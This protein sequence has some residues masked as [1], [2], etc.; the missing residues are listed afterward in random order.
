MTP[1]VTEAA[2]EDLER[3]MGVLML[4]FA[5]DPM[6]RWSFAHPDRYLRYFPVILHAFGSKGVSDRIDSGSGQP[7]AA[8]LWMP[9]GTAVD[10]AAMDA[11][12][13]DAIPAALGT[14]VDTIAAQMASFHPGEPHWHMP[15]IGVDPLCQHRG[16]G[17][18]LL[19]HGL[20]RCDRDRL[21]AY[22]ESSNPVN[23]PLYERHG[24]VRLGVIQSG[25]S[26]IMVPMLRPA[27]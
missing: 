8:T 4:A 20:E 22:L 9:P 7:A 21:P 11:A 27:R 25:T 10:Q 6:A 13:G 5:T 26:P 2:P 12:L 15:F 18:A 24:F 23:I 16:L 3:A 17:S 19:R 14:D 1:V